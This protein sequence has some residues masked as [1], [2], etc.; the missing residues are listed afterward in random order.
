MKTGDA[1]ALIV[2]AGGAVAVYFLYKTLNKTAQ[3]A[4][5]VAQ[6]ILHPT[7]VVANSVTAADNWLNNELGFNT[8]GQ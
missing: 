3:V 8:C 1:T 6:G 7:C 4:C 2:L 5:C